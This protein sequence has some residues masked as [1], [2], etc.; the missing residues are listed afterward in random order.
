SATAPTGGALQ[1]SVSEYFIH[2]QQGQAQSCSNVISMDDISKDLIGVL[3]DTG[4]YQN[5]EIDI[6]TISSDGNTIFVNGGQENMIYKKAD[7][8]WK[9]EGVKSFGY[10]DK[11]S[12]DGKTII[13]VSNKEN[14]PASNIAEWRQ[15]ND[16]WVK[17][18]NINANVGIIDAV[19]DIVIS[20]DG[21][22]LF[23]SYSFND[24]NSREIGIFEKEN[25]VW[26]KISQLVSSDD[27]HIASTGFKA[28][29]NGDYLIVES[30]NNQTSGIALLKR[31]GKNWIK[32]QNISIF[33]MHDFSYGGTRVMSI[34]VNDDTVLIQADEANNDWVIGYRLSNNT[35]SKRF[36]YEIGSANAIALSKSGKV[37]VSYKEKFGDDD[38]QVN[39]WIDTFT[40]E[41]DDLVPF[42]T[43]DSP[44]SGQYDNGFGNRLVWSFDGENLLS[45][46]TSDKHSGSNI[47]E[48][49][50]NKNRGAIYMY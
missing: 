15:S 43:M 1:A 29:E 38:S 2:A 37:A 12:A 16:G 13:S 28:T 26:T 7:N 46:A 6:T 41:N 48:E 31:E 3:N 50:N 10:L 40:I 21:Q 35:L 24:H 47:N 9:S 32:N 34:H 14:Y 42:Q 33:D 44:F 19:H 49:S 30:W 39:A 4:N 11:M 5:N 23:A 25:G 18:Q 8:E 45:V 36:E 27:L 20:D 22:V 17:K